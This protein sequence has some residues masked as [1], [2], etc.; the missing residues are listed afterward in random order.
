MK[1]EFTWL[2]LS[3]RAIIIQIWLII[4]IQICSTIISDIELAKSYVHN[5]MFP[6]DTSS[7]FRFECFYSNDFDAASDALPILYQYSII[8][9]T[10]HMYHAVSNHQK[11][12]C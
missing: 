10:S 11:P 7:C 4:C 3:V 5:I 12:Y 8:T 1:D 9:M 6:K 2:S